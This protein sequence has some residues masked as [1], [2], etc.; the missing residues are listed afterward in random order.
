MPKEADF[1]FIRERY[2]D[3]RE[4]SATGLL[5]V[6]YRNAFKEN[7][8]DLLKELGVCFPITSLPKKRKCLFSIPGLEKTTNGNM[9][10]D[11][12]KRGRNNTIG[13][14]ADIV[15]EAN[16]GNTLLIIETKKSSNGFYL[17]Q[18]LFYYL[19]SILPPNSQSFIVC[20]YVDAREAAKI[21]LH[22]ENRSPNIP[23]EGITHEEFIKWAKDRF[24]QLE[25]MLLKKDY[26]Y[27]GT[28]T[29]N[30]EAF[31]KNL[32]LIA[33]KSSLQGPSECKMETLGFT[34]RNLAANSV[35]GFR[36]VPWSG[37]SWAKLSRYFHGINSDWAD[38]VARELSLLAGYYNSH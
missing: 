15:Y 1:Q 31:R 7:N 11:L 26:S 21:T 3:N 32:N 28:L 6:L 19:C 34:L 20:P 10:D 25:G 5:D 27:P 18:E 2:I 22:K 23:R 36:L 38:I 8:P 35:I 13:R 33:E 14:S 24:T 30:E 16:D 17:Q 9:W 29:E 12:F 37:I 4:D